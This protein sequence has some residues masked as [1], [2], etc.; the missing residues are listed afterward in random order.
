MIKTFENFSGEIDDYNSIYG[1]SGRD[2]SEDRTSRISPVV[3]NKDS[4]LDSMDYIW[5]EKPKPEY[6]SEYVYQPPVKMV[7]EEEHK[8]FTKFQKWSIGIG[9][10]SLII[11]IIT[12]IVLLII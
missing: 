3:N 11:G 9:T 8:E 4:I 2:G 7:K 10:G 5:A 6:K 12:V 1:T